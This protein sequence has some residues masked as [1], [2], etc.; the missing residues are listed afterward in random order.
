MEM[1][2]GRL[3]KQVFLW[4]YQLRRNNWSY[5]MR[6]LYRE[7]DIEHVFNDLLLYSKERAW[8]TLHDN[9]CSKWATLLHTTPKLRTY[10]LF[11][12]IYCIEPY[13][14]SRLTRKLISILA[15]FRTG[16]LPLEIETGRWRSIPECQR[17]CKLCNAQSVESEM[18]FLLHCSAYVHFRTI[19]FEY[20]Q[21][22]NNTFNS[23]DD[24]EKLKVLMGAQFEAGTARLMADMYRCR[25]GS[26]FQNVNR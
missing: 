15:R 23:L 2:E 5:G 3:T 20:V 6:R 9:H 4:D 24:A 10:C 14:S 8:A 19:Y 25:Q 18:H 7:L 16:T 22:C 21:Q 13:V 26:L 12:Q 1:P 17:I 11:K